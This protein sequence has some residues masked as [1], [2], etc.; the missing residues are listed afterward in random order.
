MKITHDTTY[1]WCS[2]PGSPISVDNFSAHCPLEPCNT[3]MASLLASKLTKTRG[4]IRRVS[5]FQTFTRTYLYP[6]HI[7]Y[8]CF[9]SGAGL[10]SLLPPCVLYH[11]VPH[12]GDFT[13]HIGPSSFIKFSYPTWTIKVNT[14]LLNKPLWLAPHAICKYHESLKNVKNPER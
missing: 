13:L 1:Y 8:F 10:L 11:P 2:F 7:F 3:Y 12:L 6:W 9:S 4:T 5:H 14:Q